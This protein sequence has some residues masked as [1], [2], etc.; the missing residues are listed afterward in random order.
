MLS[1]LR[2]Q[3]LAARSTAVIHGPE[4][5]RLE[6]HYS[7]QF[8]AEL[9][10][11]SRDTIVRWFQDVP[12]VLKLSEPGKRGRRRVELRIPY[13]LACSVYEERSK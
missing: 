11:V 1:Q 9:W 6:Q 2:G 3:P 8:Y 5:I 12:G 4:Q 10:G 7:P 13:R